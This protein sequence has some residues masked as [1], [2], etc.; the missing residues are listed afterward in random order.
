MCLILQHT[1]VTICTT[2]FNIKNL[3]F[4]PLHTLCFVRFL[5]RGIVKNDDFLNSFNRLVFI[6]D[7][8]CLLLGVNRV[9]N[10]IHVTCMLE[11]VEASS[12]H[13]FTYIYIEFPLFIFIHTFC[14]LLCMSLLCKLVRQSQ[15]FYTSIRN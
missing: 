7:I 14:I 11:I 12:L 4:F 8:Q 2:C 13:D 3:H 1:V 15:Q 6:M 10:I 5:G 9:L